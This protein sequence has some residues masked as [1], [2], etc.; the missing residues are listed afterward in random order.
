MA[1][2]KHGMAY[3][4]SF[5]KYGEPANQCRSEGQQAPPFQ[6]D[7]RKTA[8]LFWGWTVLWSGMTAVRSPQ[9]VAAERTAKRAVK[10][11]KAFV[12]GLFQKSREN[13][14]SIAFMV[15]ISRRSAFEHEKFPHSVVYAECGENLYKK[16]Y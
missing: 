14:L 3:S 16:S 8:I 6:I 5:Q 9:N 12:E 10:M 15:S 2:I 1:A 11:Q 13:N 4:S 7:A